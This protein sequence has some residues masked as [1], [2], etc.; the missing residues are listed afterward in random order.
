[1]QGNQSK[2]QDALD[3][4]S[5][6][7]IIDRECTAWRGGKPCWAG[8]AAALGFL[9]A[10]A[11][12]GARLCDFTIYWGSG[13][14]LRSEYLLQIYFESSDVLRGGLQGSAGD[15]CCVLTWRNELEL[16]ILSRPLRYMAFT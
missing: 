12:R 8:E 2:L 14:I 9:E 6:K 7:Y 10:G 1:M 5:N 11:T 15:V 13:H 4:S 16:A 3:K